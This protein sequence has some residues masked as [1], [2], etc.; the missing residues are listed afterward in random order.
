MCRFVCSREGETE[1]VLIESRKLSQTIQHSEW[2]MPL[3]AA[4]V[5]L[6]HWEKKTRY[7]SKQKLRSLMV[8]RRFEGHS[9]KSKWTA[10]GDSLTLSAGFNTE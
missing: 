1:R 7:L 9:N 10:A 3:L 4:L 5:N 8:L 2:L 6:N